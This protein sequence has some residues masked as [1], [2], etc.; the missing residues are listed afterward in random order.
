MALSGDTALVSQPGMTWYPSF[1]GGPG[2]F[3]PGRVIVYVRSAGSWSEQATLT[4][5]DEE[6]PLFGPIPE[7]YPYAS[8]FGFSIAMSGET[9]VIGAPQASFTEYLGA[10]GPQ[11][12]K[13]P[14]RA[15]VFVRSG[16]TWTE[17]TK[18]TAPSSNDGS[19]FG[20]SVALAG[21]TAMV[22]AP[23]ADKIDITTGE[24]VP[25]GTVTPGSAI[26]FENTAGSTWL[27]GEQLAT[28]TDSQELNNFG[29][30]VAISGDTALVGAN[31]DSS[32]ETIHEGSAFVFVRS[33]SIW[34]FQAKL[35]RSEP[36]YGTDFGFQVAVAGD[37]ALVTGANDGVIHVFNRNGT[38]WG[39]QTPLQ[40]DS[41]AT[42]ESLAID[43][44]T[45]LAS[46]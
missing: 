20:Y 31:Q 11:Y 7:D 40:T 42:I 4:A 32:P 25:E 41:E 35:R 3:V 17:Q 37:T 21:T 8:R 9:V 43:N 23:G 46:S 5:S 15:F 19:Q 30:A 14:G 18:L 45:A 38:I 24:P 1:V 28:V 27:R 22:G 29:V 6:L 33:G 39:E 26:V 2:F 34:R 16:T 12:I 44:D 13:G 10:Y 36:G